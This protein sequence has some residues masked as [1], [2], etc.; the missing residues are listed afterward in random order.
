MGVPRHRLPTCERKIICIHSKTKHNLRFGFRKLARKFD[1]P[2]HYSEPAM[3]RSTC[4]VVKVH[5]V[6][7]LPFAKWHLHASSLFATSGHSDRR[8]S[9]VSNVG[10]NVS[11]KRSLGS[12]ASFAI[13][14]I[15]FDIFINFWLTVVY[16]SPGAH[17]GLVSARPIEIGL[18]SIT[19]GCDGAHG[20]ISSCQY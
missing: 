20:Q 13:R 5:P 3:V 9:F 2:A 10:V 11:M 17:W 4:C 8:P 14:S 6:A 1:A 18:R 7:P 16:V 19:S 15:A 12:G